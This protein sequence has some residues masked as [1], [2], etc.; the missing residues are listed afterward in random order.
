MV[1]R[2]TRSNSTDPLLFSLQQ[3]AEG[4]TDRF[5][6]EA[7]IAAHLQHPNIIIVHDVRQF[8]DL[9][10]FVMNLVEGASVDEVMRSARPTFDQIRWLLSQAAHGLAHAHS[11]GVVHRDVKPGNL[12]VNLKGD[13]IVTDFGIANATCGVRMTQTG[14]SIGTPVYMSPE[15]V[16][17]SSG[18]TAASDQY[19]LGIAAY[20]MIVGAPPFGGT[21]FE[22]QMAHV[23]REPDALITRRPDCPPDLAE[24]VYRMLSKDPEARWPS[25]EDLS[26]Q[27]AAPLSFGGGE[28]RNQLS[29]MARSIAVARI[30]VIAT[31][32]IAIACTGI[33]IA[34]AIAV[35]RTRA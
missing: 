26:G 16:V 33:A 19:S 20:E 14:M 25:L 18:L 23:Q 11:E 9:M 29:V 7:R 3:A 5:L 6:Q 28:T 32:T 10:Y 21:A 8:D 17:G 22:L 2:I 12:L 1:D 4:M 27:I 15:Q 13:L 34:I 35:S 24:I 30:S 31:V